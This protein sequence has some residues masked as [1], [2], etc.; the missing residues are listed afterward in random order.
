MPPGSAPPHPGVLGAR[1][2]LTLQE[3]LNQGAPFIRGLN[4]E[5]FIHKHDPAVVELRIVSA[6]HSQTLE[7]R[8]AG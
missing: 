1:P 6:E 3:A 5:D 2:A 7:Q 8:G 4:L